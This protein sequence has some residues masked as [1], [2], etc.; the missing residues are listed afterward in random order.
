VRDQIAHW[1][2]YDTRYVSFN[3]VDFAVPLPSYSAI[4]DGMMYHFYGPGEGPGSRLWV[5]LETSLC[6]P[7][8]PWTLRKVGSEAGLWHMKK[9]LIIGH[10]SYTPAHKE[11]CP[12]LRMRHP[13]VT[14]VG[15]NRWY[16]ITASRSRDTASKCGLYN[17][18]KPPRTRR[19]RCLRSLNPRCLLKNKRWKRSYIT[20]TTS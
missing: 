11:A 15:W 12:P 9:V 5:A 3:A 4:S 6:R 2:N 20:H 13:S 14:C 19:P 8:R 17:Q 18:S 10:P 1:H 16:S 7:A